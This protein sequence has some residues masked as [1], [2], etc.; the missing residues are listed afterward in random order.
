M[1]LPGSKKAV[2]ECFEILAP[3]LQHVLD[4]S[5]DS[6]PAIEGCHST[7]SEVPKRE[8]KEHVCPHKTQPNK[9]LAASS[10]QPGVAFR[11]RK[12]EWPMMKVEKALALIV[13]HS[14]DRCE[15]VKHTIDFSSAAPSARYHVLAETLLAREEV[16]NYPASIK[17]GYAVIASDGPGVYNVVTISQTG[18]ETVAPLTAGSVARVTT[19]APVPHGADAVVQVPLP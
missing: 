15:F 18:D 7:L 5:K 14:K 8:F 4:L 17:D 16:P 19:G 6:K 12:S 1:C 13:Q 11:P 3:V 9:Q 10:K 2:T